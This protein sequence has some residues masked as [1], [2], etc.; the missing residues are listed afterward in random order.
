[1]VTG[2]TGDVMVASDGGWLASLYNAFNDS[3]KLW[4]LGH[5]YVEVSP[6]V[7]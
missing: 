2:R 6:L 1:V 7:L 3:K 5:E 4:P